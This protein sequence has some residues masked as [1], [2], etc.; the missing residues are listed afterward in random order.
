MIANI[1]FCTWWAVWVGGLWY[2]TLIHFAG[3]TIT[4]APTWRY[5]FW[6]FLLLGVGNTVLSAVNLF[7][8]YW[9]VTRASIRLVSDAVGSVLFCWMMRANILAALSVVNVAPEKTAQIAHAINWWSATMFPLAVIACAIIAAVDAY[10]IFRVRSNA[11]PGIVLSA[12][13]RIR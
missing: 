2:Q 3:V 5:F 9:T 4:L 6:G 11:G 13:S 10:R 1:A 8:P 7:R 12:V